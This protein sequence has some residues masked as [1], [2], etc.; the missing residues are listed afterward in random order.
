MGERALPF[1]MQQLIR[2]PEHWFPALNA[3]VD[4]EV[5]PSN[6]AFSEAVGAWLEWGRR[7]GYVDVSGRV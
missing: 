6:L 2:Q 5:A 7:R 3:I 1:I 4:E